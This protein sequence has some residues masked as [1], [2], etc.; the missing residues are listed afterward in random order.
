[1]LSLRKERLYLHIF[2]GISI[3][4]S[5]LSRPEGLFLLVLPV[6]QVF[7]VFSERRSFSGSRLLKTLIVVII[8]IFA[9]SPYMIFLKDYTGTFTLSGKGNVSIILGELSG[10]MGYHEIVNAP[11]NLYDRAAFTL[12]EQ[13]TEL[14]GWNKKK[15][16][17]LKDYIF[18]DPV[19]L[20]SR[21]QRNIFNE[22]K[23]LTKLIMPIILPLF[24]AFFDRELFRRRTRLI[25]IIFPSVFFLLYPLFIIIEKQ[26]LFI[27]LFLIFFSSG[28]FPN[29]KSV[30]SDISVYYGI[31]DSRVVGT[32]GN[33]IKYL[34]IAVLMLSSLSY[35]KYSSFDKAPM[36]LE[37]KG[38]GRYLKEEVSSVYEELN[39]MSRKPY[40]S[41]YS[42]SRFTMLPY[43]GTADV[44]DFA[45]L[46]G[47]DYI[48]ID[49]RSLG[50]WD[51]YMELAEIQKYSHDVEMVYEDSSEMLIRLFRVKK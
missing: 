21:Y 42:D 1:M 39:V 17:S 36:P 30:I 19:N 12:D 20:L 49:E 31:G 10:E 32:I 24:F 43:A 41:F 23:T 8:F 11:D 18:R 51:Y 33:G 16:L 34:M 46:Y 29:S 50:K 2:L 4:L 44:V 13:K 40:V 3:S 9:V 14:R 28:G 27:V 38:A 45:K 25:F 15:N 7:G 48:V 6:I 47:V 22:I 5:F 26:T 37:H 35:L